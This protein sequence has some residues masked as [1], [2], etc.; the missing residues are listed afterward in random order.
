M[1]FVME[2]EA[3]TGGMSRRH[4]NTSPMSVNDWKLCF[5]S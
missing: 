4:G 2:K 5:V 1:T 3:S